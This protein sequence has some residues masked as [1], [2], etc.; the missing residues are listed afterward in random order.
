MVG[1]DSGAVHVIAVLTAA[2]IGFLAGVLYLAGKIDRREEDRE[3]AY[4]ESRRR[5]EDDLDR[6]GTISQLV[7]PPFDWAA[8]VEE[9]RRLPEVA[10]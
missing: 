9:I 5:A 3:R 8:Q 7:C 4:W 6:P 1:R 2:I 10:S